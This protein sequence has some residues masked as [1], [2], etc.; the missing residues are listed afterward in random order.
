M[1][2]QALN[3]LHI[4]IHELEVLFNEVYLRHSVHVILLNNIVYVSSQIE[5]YF[6][7]DHRF[8]DVKLQK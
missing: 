5:A 7:L 8:T 6:K 2:V 3:L 1:P 4:F